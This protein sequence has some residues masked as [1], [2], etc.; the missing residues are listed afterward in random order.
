[1]HTSFLSHAGGRY[2]WLSMLLTAACI[3]LYILDEPTEPPN[4]GTWLGYG[5]G[6][7]GALLIVWL[8]Y[9]G[10]RKRNFRRGWGTVRGWVSAHVYF[11]TV[12]LIIA[13]LHTGFQFGLNI[14]T[15]AYVLM[16]LVIAS[17]LFGVFAYRTY[18]GARND[19]KKSQTL[20]EIFL[21]VEDLDARL[22]RLINGAPNDVRSVVS[23]A[24]ER[25]VIGGGFLDQLLGRDHSVAQIDGQVVDNTGQQ[26]TLEYLVERV[27]RAQGEDSRRLSEIVDAFNS[28]K[29]LL[30]TIRKDIKMHAIIGVWLMFH[31]PMTFALLA[32]LLAHIFA[33]FIYW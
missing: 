5:L 10:R 15:L 3:T 28:R 25:T 22:N 11:G 14:H 16:C 30:D 27:T 1:M 24:L 13:T 21:K 7:I 33:V 18:P 17:G 6:T 9:L 2:F 19:L 29:R 31:V 23:S 4:G 20:D 26:R 32:A 12:L 8:A